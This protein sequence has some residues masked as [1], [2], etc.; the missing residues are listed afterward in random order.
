MVGVDERCIDGSLA[1]DARE[2]WRRS[3]VYSGDLNLR[4]PFDRPVSW[5]QVVDEGRVIVIKE[6]G[7]CGEILVVQCDL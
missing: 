7:T 4:T 3:E 2:D 5:D 1:K 6:N